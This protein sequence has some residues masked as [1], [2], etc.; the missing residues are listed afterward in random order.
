MSVNN[1]SL[2]ANVISYSLMLRAYNKYI[3]DKP[4][5]AGLPKERLIKVQYVRYMT[6]AVLTSFILPVAVVGTSYF[7]N[8]LIETIFNIFPVPQPP[9]IV[10]NSPNNAFLL[11]LL[12]KSIAPR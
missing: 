8:P 7:K 9:Q 6:R 5:P 4:L 11:T 3:Y 10:E 2:L 1:L 12:N